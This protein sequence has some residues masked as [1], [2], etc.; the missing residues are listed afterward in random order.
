MDGCTNGCT[1]EWSD[2]RMIVERTD[3]TTN[4][5]TAGRMGSCEDERSDGTE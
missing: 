1:N 2:G 5:W 4:G 3:G